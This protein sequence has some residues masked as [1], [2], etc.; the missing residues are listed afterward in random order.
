LHDDEKKGH[1]GSNLS[2]A[3]LSG[4][5]ISRRRHFHFIL[6]LTSMMWQVA[7]RGRK[8]ERRREME[9]W[10]NLE[11]ASVA[12]FINKLKAIKTIPRGW[13]SSS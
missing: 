2:R 7:W 3:L 9:G 12:K 4:L 13:Y 10:K 1:Y 6:V 8:F 11:K 5:K